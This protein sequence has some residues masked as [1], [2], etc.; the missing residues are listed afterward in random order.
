VEV[1]PLLIISPL[2][3]NPFSYGRLIDVY[4]KS[5]I[6]VKYHFPTFN[7]CSDVFLVPFGYIAV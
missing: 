3:N 5:S 1:K 4:C 2:G 7:N 6:Q